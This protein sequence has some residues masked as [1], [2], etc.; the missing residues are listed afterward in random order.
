MD[1]EIAAGGFLPGAGIPGT[2]KYEAE[3]GPGMHDIL[4]VL[5]A[6]S[7][8]VEDKRAFLK[9]QIILWM[10]AAVDG[11]AKNYSIF[12]ERGGTYRLAPFYDILSAWPVSGRGVNKL[13]VHKAK[14]AMAVRSKNAHWKLKE[15]KPHHW[16]AVARDAGLGNARSML[17]EIV[18]LAPRVVETAGRRIPKNFPSVVLDTILA[19]LRR[20]AADIAMIL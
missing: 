5:E 13:D 11:H 18:T 9:A 7:R 3:G 17:Q 10:L 6:G 8:A 16:D 20:T 1:C 19:G 14:L 12:H 4:R 2:K 15:I